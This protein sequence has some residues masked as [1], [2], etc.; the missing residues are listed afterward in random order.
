MPAIE[1]LGKKIKAKY[2]GAYDDMDDRSLALKIQSKYPGAYDDF[3]DVSP[4]ATLP[5]VAAPSLT[6]RGPAPAAPVMQSAVDPFAP[7]QDWLPSRPKPPRQLQP[8]TLAAPE[9]AIQPAPPGKIPQTIETS[10]VGQT[11][12][13]VPG[14]IPGMERLGGAA[15]GVPMPPMAMGAPAPA[16]LPPPRRVQ[17]V[18][19]QANE[20]PPPPAAVIST[21]KSGPVPQVAEGPAQ[22]FSEGLGQAIDYTAQQVPKVLGSV[23]KVNA[24]MR[25][26]QTQVTPEE[27]ESAA[28]V[29]NEPLVKPSLMIPDDGRQDSTRELI[30]GA[31]EGVE[32][33]TTPETLAV[34]GTTGG[35]AKA[36]ETVASPAVKGA[37][38][39][40]TTALSLYFTGQ[41]GKG[42]YESGKTAYELHQKGD[43]EGAAR[44]L[45][46]ASVDALFAVLGVAHAASE[47]VGGAK[48]FKEGYERGQRRREAVDADAEAKFEA[49]QKKLQAEAFEEIPGEPGKFRIKQNRGEAAPMPEPPQQAVE[50]APQEAK[51]APIE[52]KGLNENQPPNQQVAPPV[53]PIPPVQEEKP[54]PAP[55][56]AQPAPAPQPEPSLSQDAEP[57]RKFSSTQVNLPDEV[58]NGVRELAARIPDSDLADDGRETEPHITV[59]YGLHGNDAEAVRSLLADEPPVRVKL[60]KVSLFENDDADVVKIEVDSPDLHRLNKKIADALPVTDTHPDYKPH[61]TIAY[62][63]P[64]MGKKYV[65][66]LNGLQGKEITLN[67]L[68]FSGKDRTTTEIPLGGNPSQSSAEPV[69]A[70]GSREEVVQPNPAEAA[71][72]VAEEI[73]DSNAPIPPEAPPSPGAVE[74]AAPQGPWSTKPSEDWRPK[75]GLNLQQ[76]PAAPEP[77]DAVEPASAVVDKITSGSKTPYEI[78]DRLIDAYVKEPREDVQR[79]IKRRLTDLQDDAETVDMIGPELMGGIRFI[80]ADKPIGAENLP[81]FPVRRA[82]DPFSTPLVK[83]EPQSDVYRDRLFKL[84][85]R[86]R[87]GEVPTNKEMSFLSDDDRAYIVR[88]GKAEGVEIPSRKAKGAAAGAAS[89]SALPPQTVIGRRMPAKTA[90]GYKVETNFAVVPMSSLRISNTDNGEV[91]PGYPAELQPRQRDRKSSEEQI[92]GIIAKFDPDQV[93]ESY[94]ATDGAPIIGDDMAVESGNGRSM[95]LRRIYSMHPEKANQYRQWLLENADRFGLDAKAVEAVDQPVLVRIRKGLPE[96][97]SRADFGRDANERTTSKMSDAEQAA[98]D[99]RAMS[100]DLIDMF[101]PNEDGDI[102]TV[103]N[104]PFVRAFIEKVIPESERGSMRSGD[105]MLST[106]GIRRIQNAIF[107]RAYNDRGMIERMTED[108]DDNIKSVVGAM[109]SAAPRF[110]SMRSAIESGDLHDLDIAN[111]LT[112]AASVLS[113][114]RA[115]RKSIDDYLKQE[116]MFGRPEMRDVILATMRDLGRNKAKFGDILNRYVDAVEAAGNPKQ[117]GMFGPAEVPTP[118]ALWAG[119]VEK[120]QVDGRAEDIAAPGPVDAG[121]PAGGDAGGQKLPAK[122]RRGKAGPA[123]PGAPDQ[124]A[125]SAGT[126]LGNTVERTKDGL[127]ETLVTDLEARES[128]IAAKNDR[129]RPLAEVPFSLVAEEPPAPTGPDERQESM[130]GDGEVVGYAPG[131]SAA[132]RPGTPSKAPAKPTKAPGGKKGQMTSRSE[133][134]RDLSSFL[135]DIPIRTGGF[136]ERAAG[137]FKVRQSVIRSKQALDLPTI[138]HE[139]GHAIHKYLWGTTVKN[140]ARLNSKP[141]MPFRKELGPLDYDQ[142]QQRPFEGFAEYIRLRLT[143]PNVAQQKAPRFH[144]WFENQLKTHTDLAEVLKQAEERVGDWYKQPAAAKIAASINTEDHAPKPWIGTLERVWSEAIDDRYAIKKAVDEFKAAGADTADAQDA[145]SLSR[146]LSGWSE[147]AMQFLEEGTFNPKTLKT[148]GKPLRDILKPIYDRKAADINPRFKKLQEDWGVKIAGD[149]LDDLRLYLVARRMENYHENGLETGFT[150]DQV[151]EAIA[152]TETPQLKAAANAIHEYQDQVLQYAVELGGLSQEAAD[153]IRDKNSLY[154]PMYR[155]MD[156]GDTKFAAGGRKMIDAKSPIHKRRGSTREIIDP[157]ESIVKNTYAMISYAERNN[158]GQALVKQAEK[159]DGKGSILESGI[160]PGMKVTKFNLQE[161]EPQIKKI[162]EDADIDTE[163]LD[164]DVM[165]ALYRPKVDPNRATNQVAITVDGV[166]QIFEMHPDLIKAMGVVDQHSTRTLAKLL[167]APADLLRFG[168]TGAGP[169][170]IFRNPIRDTQDAFMQSENNF[171]PVVDTIW[172]GIKMLT[173]KP[174]VQ[175]MVRAGGGGAGMMPIGRKALRRYIDEM[176]VAKPQYVLKHPAEIFHVLGQALRMAGETTERMTRVGEYRRARAKGKSPFQAAMDERN[177]SL[178]FSRQGSVARAVNP[179]IAYFSASLNGSARFFETHR[180]NPARTIARGLIGVT[181]P[182]IAL[183]MMNKDDEEYKEQPAWKKNLFWLVPTKGFPEPIRKVF[184]P[185]FMIPRAHLYGLVYGNMVERALDAHYKKNPKAFDGFATDLFT[186]TAPPITPTTVT[187]P[188]EAFFNRSFFTQQPIEGRGLEALQPQFRSKPTTSAVAKATSKSLAQLGIDI[189]PLKL[190]HILYGYTAG[191][192]RAV[193]WGAEKAA[194]KVTGD[195]DIKPEATGAN[196]PIIRAFATEEVGSKSLSDFYDQLDKLRKIRDS[197]KA[198]EKVPNGPAA[199]ARKMTTAES[200]DLARMERASKDL[201]AIT[202]KSSIVQYDQKMTPEK[203][204]AE[205]T[206]LQK[207]KVNIARRA[208]G[209]REVYK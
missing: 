124:R 188:L 121:N 205:L 20:I 76:E 165:A 201:A 3:T 49:A 110:I 209:L 152:A 112:S 157:I 36:A 183:W 23:P 47:A 72:P 136:R 4:V 61:V 179:Y 55:L 70:P 75:T 123:S 11:N 59:K 80:M 138:A 172:G 203:K 16:P 206:R 164:F 196:T 94:I 28:Q 119:I 148:E 208:I 167:Q 174:L 113:R 33:L 153:A 1:E 90:R 15:P 190:D 18:Q 93:A 79:A 67:A 52:G 74:A 194:S 104:A 26:G 54:A 58:A 89:D 42:A 130:F 84:K 24:M 207:L 166:R 81:T 128:Q 105:G 101:S 186:A 35:I 134:V 192:G 56:G 7:K 50:V 200:S 99:A 120:E 114:L 127:Q 19:I 199:G 48:S 30:R 73:K 92:Q 37:L 111:D 44:Y 10:P 98:V 131:K 25:P 85:G 53:A 189:S 77:V 62:V 87:K 184:G 169:E 202:T 182:T 60:G 40:A 57:E 107:A 149:N 125:S 86:I 170:F 82:G 156:S 65:E 14:R 155:V 151:K 195:P 69:P 95:A 173:D 142:K 122:T 34:I 191:F 145:Y 71:A 175:E 41:A 22:T 8:S 117:V 187:P 168:A 88:F 2:P 150:K 115:E 161:I 143:Q 141:L 63:K 46:L 132:F 181:L 100:S 177:V 106:A 176:L 13:P 178:D 64:G 6:P 27:A 32:G 109:V 102:D 163:D 185:F 31:I 118:R 162:L 38:K 133:I 158:V 78:A 43:D 147:K 198:A 146:L 159:A 83:T 180:K 139:I 108:P 68:T 171:I 140:N 5:P 135:S 160:H 197:R 29:V 204:R 129:N 193:V 144:A 45:G 116:D 12:A 97:V 96:G 91:T 9:D 154:V 66:S 103:A 17:N 51:P 126:A 39:G 21:A 137:I